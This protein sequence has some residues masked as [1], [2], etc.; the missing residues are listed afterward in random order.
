MTPWSEQ[1]PSPD[2]IDLTLERLPPLLRKHSTL[3]LKVMPPLLGFLLFLQYFYRN[4]FYPS[5]DLFQFSSLLLAA[6]CVGVLIVGYVVILL[7]LPGVVVFHGYVNNQQ[8]KS[9]I[10]QN[11][12]KADRAR[13]NKVM[14]LAALA[15]FGPFVTT[16]LLFWPAVY[17]FPGH[18]VK[19]MIA[20]S[21]LACA[22]YGLL[23]A[24]RFKL[25]KRTTLKFVWTVFF[26]AMLFIGLTFQV[27]KGSAEAL[28]RLP[29]WLMLA[30]TVLLICVLAAIA[31][32]SAIAHFAGW[33][34]SLLFGTF[35]GILICGYS[36]LLTSLPETVVRAVGLGAYEAK[37]V[38]LDSAFCDTGLGVTSEQ[39]CRLESPTIVWSLGETLV[40]RT[41]G[42]ESVQLQIPSH[43]VKAIVQKAN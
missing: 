25:P 8:V 10:Q 4:Q 33:N 15:Y 23:I 17:W 30:A 19:L 38:E 2:F 22:P 6:A 21:V 35:F 7:T 42:D 16:G 43:L 20:T 34:A 9:G 37:S 26:A 3:L 28:D 29:P 39:R 36:G 11:L 32:I 31:S 27:L 14:E 41:A 40:V 12:P 5:F 24:L 13:Q 1:P 18:T